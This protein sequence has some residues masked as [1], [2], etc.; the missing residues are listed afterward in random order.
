MEFQRPLSLKPGDKV[1]IIS[2]SSGMPFLFPWVYE[3]GLDRIEEI[4]ELVPVEFPTARQSPEYLSQ[5][6]QAR[7]EDINSGFCR[8]F[9]QRHYRNNRRK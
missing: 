1:A 3:Q 5:N 9:Y 6:P 7:A 8:C 4:F 2:P